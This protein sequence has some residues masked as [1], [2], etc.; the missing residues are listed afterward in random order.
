[1]LSTDPGRLT[2]R[3]PIRPDL[4]APHD[5]LH[6]GTLVS[7][8]DTLCG[9]GAIVNLPDGSTG[10]VTVELNCSYLGTLRTGALFCEATP[11]HVG[12]STHVW[13]AVVTDEDSGRRLAAVRCT[14]LV[15]WPAN[16]RA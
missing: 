9:Y 16:H 4:L 1:V 10:F 13:D 14:Q 12:R 8:A 2:C 11:M 5:Y 15:L 3:V 6:G 7:V